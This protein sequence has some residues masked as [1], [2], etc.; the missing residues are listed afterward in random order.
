MM[1]RTSRSGGKGGQNVNKVETKVELLFDIDNSAQFDDEQKQLIKKALIKRI[2]DE[3]KISITAQAERTQLGNK[4]LAYDKL[5]LLL[6][7]ALQKKK[8]RKAT[9]MPEEVK[10]QIKAKKQ[11]RAKQKEL[12]RKPELE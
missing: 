7:R 1:Y 8:E 10:Q 11:Q 12:R 9:A 3:G 4:K 5:V 6:T 2:N